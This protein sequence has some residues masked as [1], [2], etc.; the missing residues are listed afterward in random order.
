[1]AVVCMFECEFFVVSKLNGCLAKMK[2]YTMTLN[3]EAEITGHVPLNQMD[4]K[5]APAGFLVGL[6]GRERTDAIEIIID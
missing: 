2:S 6:T 1:M 4:P 5:S 3:Y